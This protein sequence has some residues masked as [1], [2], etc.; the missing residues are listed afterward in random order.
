MSRP[1]RIE[2]PGAWYHV[3]PRGRR[4]ERIFFNK[5]DYRNFVDLLKEGS[6]LWKVKVISYCL[7]PNH[8][9][10]LINTPL[11]NLSR[12][13]RHI[14]GLYTQTF[15]RKHKYDGALF[16]GRFK[17]ILVNGDNYLLQLMRYIHR[18]P[19]EARIVKDLD[20]YQWSS[21]IGYISKS[22]TWNWLYKKYIFSILSQDK[23]ISIFQYTNFINQKDSKEVLDLFNKSRWPSFWGG[24][25]F[26]NWIKEKFYK[27]KVH[28][29]VP[30]SVNLAPDMIK[31]I[32]IVQEL[33]NLL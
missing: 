5:S 13:M 25:D 16:R 30:D 24:P 31:I 27:Q 8:F 15:N 3:M 26:G 9:H 18:N 1:L 19:L 33:M 32:R 7:M 29:E 23:C 12:F 10:L 11:G 17:S 21:H 14:D 20:D 6:E 22:T 28:K 2:Y 4:G